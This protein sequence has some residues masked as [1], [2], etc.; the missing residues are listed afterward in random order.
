MRYRHHGHAVLAIFSHPHS[1]QNSG[2]S[3]G[4]EAF[5]VPCLDFTAKSHLPHFP[6][7]FIAFFHDCEKTSSILIRHHPM[8]ISGFP[9]MGIPKDV[10]E[11]TAARWFSENRAFR[12]ARSR[13]WSGWPSEPPRP[14]GI[15]RWRI[16]WSLEFLQKKGDMAGEAIN[17]WD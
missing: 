13:S 9:E 10:S 3:G 12:A 1:P 14:C 7:Y 6:A 5:E 15:P 8:S 2:G 4:R 16:P 11:T 17:L